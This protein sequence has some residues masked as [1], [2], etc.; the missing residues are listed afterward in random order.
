MASTPLGVE[1][2]PDQSAVI[3]LV[4]FL[5]RRCR[6]AEQNNGNLRRALVLLMG[7]VIAVTAIALV[8]AVAV[9][10]VAEAVLAPGYSTWAAILTLIS[11]DAVGGA[12][13]IL[14]RLRRTAT[15]RAQVSALLP[16]ETEIERLV[17]ANETRAVLHVRRPGVHAEFGIDV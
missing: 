13:V 10:V 9:A 1:G 4:S 3:A 11:T 15:P 16:D 7:F 6:Y 8:L 14:W 17:E 2:T 5:D 12:T